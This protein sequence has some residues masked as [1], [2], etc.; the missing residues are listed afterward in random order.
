[1]YRTESREKAYLYA[2][3]SAGV[4]YAM[5]KACALGQLPQFCGCDV[6]I[7]QKD[8]KGKWEWGGCSDDV[9]F[10]SQF[11]EDFADVEEDENS[12]EGMANAHNYEAGRR[13][14]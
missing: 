11:T 13:V 5:T 10:G 2:I 12:P 14:R 1:M 4:T 8:T 9:R 7:K 3:S 6:R